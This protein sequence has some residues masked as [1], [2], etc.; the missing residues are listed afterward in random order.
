MLILILPR[1]RN[2]LSTVKDKSISPKVF[3]VH[4]CY[5]AGVWSEWWPTSHSTSTL[6][7]V[8]M[9]TF[10]STLPFYVTNWTLLVFFSLRS[11]SAT[12]SYCPAFFLPP[13]LCFT[14]RSQSPLIMYILLIM[15]SVFITATKTLRTG[16]YA[17][18]F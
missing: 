16:L 8:I 14:H 15:L 4:Y 10:P 6:R 12:F 5:Y 7:S 1:D 3:F 18:D 17:A 11:A 2:Y 13:C 9:D